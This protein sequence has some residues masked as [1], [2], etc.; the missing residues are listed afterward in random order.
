MRPVIRELIVGGIVQ[1]CALLFATTILDM[2]EWAL[3]TSRISAAFWVG[4]IIVLARCRNS[5]TRGDR[6]YLRYGLVPML[7]VGIPFTLAIWAHRVTL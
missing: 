3:A 1:L 2:G 5:L 6:R 4:V 7:A